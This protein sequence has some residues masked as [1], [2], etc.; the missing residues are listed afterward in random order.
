MIFLEGNTKQSFASLTQTKGLSEHFPQ[1][2]MQ[3]RR[4]ISVILQRHK[5][6]ETSMAPLEL[7]KTFL[8]IW[9]QRVR[10]CG[11]DGILTDSQL[12]GS[13]EP[14]VSSGDVKKTW[15]PGP[16]HPMPRYLPKGDKNIPHKCY[17]QMLLSFL[18]K[19]NHMPVTK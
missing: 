6:K 2:G 19:S 14:F 10:V 3:M 16:S 1:G 9:L 5:A 7:V 13:M 12:E 15:N 18:T 4:P 11:A 17:T 8:K